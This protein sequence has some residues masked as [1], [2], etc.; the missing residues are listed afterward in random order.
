MAQMLGL[1]DLLQHQ[2]DDLYSAEE[3][4]IEALPKMVENADNAELKNALAEHL[5]ITNEHKKRLQQI[6]EILKKESEP[7][8]EPN[9][10]QR[11]FGGPKC[12]GM[13]GLIKE[14]EHLMKQDMDSDVKDAGIIA[15]AQKVEHYEIAGY[16]TARAYATQLGMSDVENLLTQTLDEEYNANDLLTELAFFDVNL[17]AEKSGERKSRQRR[18]NII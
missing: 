9:F 2:I 7:S 6:K 3:Q 8:K 5:D 4:I 18:S 12:K 11:I 16:G 17:E 1:R 10:L 15:A 14:G 13:E